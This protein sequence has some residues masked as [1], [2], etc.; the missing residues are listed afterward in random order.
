MIALRDF[1]RGTGETA[2]RKIPLQVFSRDA[3][4]CENDGRRWEKQDDGVVRG[5]CWWRWCK[6]RGGLQK[7]SFEIFLPPFARSA[8]R[9]PLF[10]LSTVHLTLKCADD[11]S[12]FPPRF[13]LLL[14]AFPLPRLFG[15]LFF[16]HPYP[17][18]SRGV[19]AFFVT[20]NHR[21]PFPLVDLFPLVGHNRILMPVLMPARLDYSSKRIFMLHKSP[22]R[23]KKGREG[24][25]DFD[26][27]YH[28]R[29]YGIHR[30]F[31]KSGAYEIFTQACGNHKLYSYNYYN[32]YNI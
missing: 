17:P 23:E 8:R 18:R 14:R 7:V 19:T 25:E 32:Y 13:A 1:L 24:G 20:V 27:Q 30:I 31:A 15:N 28:S 16:F 3:E 5:G 2:S 9:G 11:S 26:S 12:P 10:I 21:Y 6:A 4:S 29:F 22:R